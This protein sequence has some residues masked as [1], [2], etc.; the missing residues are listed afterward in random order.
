MLGLQHMTPVK[1]ALFTNF[2]DLKCYDLQSHSLLIFIWLV[3]FLSELTIVNFSSLVNDS[4]FAHLAQVYDI[5]AVYAKRDTPKYFIEGVG[6]L[7]VMCVLFLWMMCSE[8]H[9]ENRHIKLIGMKVFGL[10]VYGFR[11]FL[12]KNLA[13]VAYRGY[14]QGNVALLILLYIAITLICVI[15]VLLEEFSV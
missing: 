1:Q 3:R 8:T 13:D 12:V 4:S 9:G 6:V 5:M 14:K 10:M 2:L 15:S 7:I 11:V